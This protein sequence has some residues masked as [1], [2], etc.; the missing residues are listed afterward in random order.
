M[1]CRETGK[2]RATLT[3]E[4]LSRLVGRRVRFEWG[5][6]FRFLNP[7]D[8]ITEPVGCL[9]YLYVKHQVGD[10]ADDN[11]FLTLFIHDC[12]VAEGA[13]C[14]QCVARSRVNCSSAWIRVR[15]TLAP[16]CFIISLAPHTANRKGQTCVKG[17]VR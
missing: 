12:I 1:P 5:D 2:Q 14:G 4:G 9:F 15:L 3:V 6:I 17:L 16:R 8:V 10:E 7:A 11:G 13:G